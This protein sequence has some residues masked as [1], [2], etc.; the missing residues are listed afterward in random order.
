LTTAHD[1][2]PPP[3]TNIG[4]VIRLA[5]EGKRMTQAELGLAI[6]VTSRT[7]GSY[8]RGVIEPPLG[9]VPVIGQALGVRF[10][11]DGTGRFEAR[12]PAPEPAPA[13]QVVVVVAATAEAMREALD[14]LGVPRAE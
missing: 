13:P 5:R 7:I 4:D 3:R 2:D 1:I 6:G 8:E 10:V 12:A 9:L 11:D 14:R